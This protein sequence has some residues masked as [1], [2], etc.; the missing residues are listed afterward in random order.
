V[1]IRVVPR[2][3]RSAV[4]GRRGDA[5]LVRLSAAPVEGAA[6]EALIGLI[7]EALGVPRRAVSLVAGGRSRN[8]RLRV[9]GLRPAE[10]AARLGA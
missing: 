8:K 1:S 10:A 9:E 7:A 2:A 4:S 5:L 6:N 3:G